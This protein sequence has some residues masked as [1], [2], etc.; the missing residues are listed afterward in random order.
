[1][2][3]VGS[4]TIDELDARTSDPV[5]LAARVGVVFQDPASQLVMERAEDDVAFGL[6]NRRWE[7]GRMHQRVPEALSSVGLGGFERE[8]SRRLSGGEQQRLAL[9]GVLAPEPAVL[10]LDEPT[11]NLDA[12]G[13]SA[14]FERIAAIRAA[15]GATIVLVEHRVDAAWPLADKVLALDAAGGAIDLGPPAAVL[16]RSRARMESAGIWLPSPPARRDGRDPLPA[17]QRIGTPSDG[18]LV[19]ARHVRYGYDARIPVIR[20]VDLVAR[21]GE[22]I[23]LIGPN[24]SGK[25]TL[26]RLLVGLLRPRQGRIRVGG[27]DPARLPAAELARRAGYVFQDPESQFLAERVEDEVMLG[28]REQEHARA[29][30]LME[31]LRLPLGEFGARSPY[32]LSGG[33]KRR[34]SLA[35]ILVRSPG[36]LVLDEPTFGQDRR[37]YEDLVAILG[38]HLGA[39]ACLIAATHDP[40][41]VDDVAERVVELADGWIVSDARVNGAIGQAPA[42]RTQPGRTATTVDA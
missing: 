31:R 1:G 11:A 25:S 16:R 36:L 28:L 14:F 17:A 22:R 23:A 38:E 32:R 5:A 33:E 37:G 15:R 12:A 13:T 10:V 41:F 3:L 21:A 4:L 30:V 39:G 7:A 2:E 29:A 40:R 8:R 20:D 19:H 6:E 26:G 18:L 24:G 34:L 42:G 35:T 9:A 27:D